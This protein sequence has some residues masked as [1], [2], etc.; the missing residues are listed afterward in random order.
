L[1]QLLQRLDFLPDAGF[2]TSGSLRS[3]ALC[4]LLCAAGGLHLGHLAKS[5]GLKDVPSTLAA[6]QHKRAATARAPATGYAGAGAQATRKK[7]LSLQERMRR[8]PAKGGAVGSSF[9]M[10][11]FAAAM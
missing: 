9:K 6:Q 8:Q 3:A 11:E 5:F 2:L 7:K 10:S 4:L 1:P